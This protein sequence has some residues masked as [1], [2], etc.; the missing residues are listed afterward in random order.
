[1]ESV[2]VLDFSHILMTLLIQSTESLY[3]FRVGFIHTVEILSICNIYAA[4]TF[5]PNAIM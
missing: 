1:M 3:L 4:C 5:N 2:A